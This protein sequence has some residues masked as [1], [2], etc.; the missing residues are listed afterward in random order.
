MLIVAEAEV[1]ALLPLVEAPS[2][3]VSLV[4]YGPTAQRF[5]SPSVYPVEGLQAALDRAES[6]LSE[7][8]FTVPCSERRLRPELPVVWIDDD[9]LCGEPPD[10]FRTAALAI[11]WMERQLNAWSNHC[12]HCRAGLRCAACNEAYQGKTERAWLGEKRQAL[13]AAHHAPALLDYLQ[14]FPAGEGPFFSV[15]VYPSC[16]SSGSLPLGDVPFLDRTTFGTFEEAVKALSLVLT[17]VPTRCAEDACSGSTRGSGASWTDTSQALEDQS[18][19]LSIGSVEY[20]AP[21]SGLLIPKATRPLVAECIAA[22]LEKYSDACEVISDHEFDKD[23]LDIPATPRPEEVYESEFFGPLRDP[24]QDL[25]W[26]PVSFP[27]RP[28]DAGSGRSFVH[29]CGQMVSP[30]SGV[31]TYAPQHLLCGLQRS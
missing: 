4:A 11:R 2:S 7:H 16:E 18:D 12:G 29:M 31:L 26:V 23:A 9:A 14:R 30:Y 24:R 10:V 21:L 1:A 3:T 19:D 5:K 22:E 28:C 27:A 6:G 8:V 13:V 25:L 20:D 15:A 17:P